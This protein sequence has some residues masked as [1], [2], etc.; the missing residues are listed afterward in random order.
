MN[1]GNVL[2]RAARWRTALAAGLLA[3]LP[4]A[5]HDDPDRQPVPPASWGP[6]RA[7]VVA[8]RPGYRLDLN[9]A[10]WPGHVERVTVRVR[11]IK[12]PRDA[13][14]D[15]ECGVLPPPDAIDYADD[16]LH[17]SPALDVTEVGPGPGGDVLA[18]V[19]LDGRDLGEALVRAG[20][21]APDDAAHADYTFCLEPDREDRPIPAAH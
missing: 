21:A 10:V 9:V 18:R 6:Y 15:D 3:A 12:P 7:A 19:V 16:W 13:P 2:G 4:C 8:V 5:A 17:E 14:L 20:L 11:G 1:L